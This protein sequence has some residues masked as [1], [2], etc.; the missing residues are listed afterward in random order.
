MDRALSR[1]IRAFDSGP[2]AAWSFWAV[3]AFVFGVTFY[4]EI[5]TIIVL[6][7]RAG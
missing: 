4:A 2:L 6:I 3:V 1:L 5:A 7:G